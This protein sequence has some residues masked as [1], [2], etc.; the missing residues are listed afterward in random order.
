VKIT[1]TIDTTK[2]TAASIATNTATITP[3]IA[4]RHWPK[5]DAS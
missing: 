1:D 3:N 5:E 2:S 4:S